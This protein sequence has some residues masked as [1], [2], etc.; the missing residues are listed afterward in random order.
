MNYYINEFKNGK[1]DNITEE[2]NDLGTEK[3][4]SIRKAIINNLNEWLNYLNI[5]QNDP[6]WKPRNNLFL[7]RINVSLDILTN[8]ND[9]EMGLQLMDL[10]KTI[11][12]YIDK[13]D[14]ENVK[15]IINKIKEL[16]N[17]NGI[18]KTKINYV[19]KENLDDSIKISKYEYELLKKYEE[20]SYKMQRTDFAL[21]INSGAV[22][23]A[24]HVN[25]NNDRVKLEIYDSNNHNIEINGEKY[26]IK[27]QALF[28]KI[29]SF[30]DNNL[31][32][33]I[34][35]SKKETNYFLDNNAYDGGK[36][37]NIKVKYGQLL[38]NV[39]GQVSGELGKNIED[40]INKIKELIISG[41]ISNDKDY[42]IY[43]LIENNQIEKNNSYSDNDET[44][45]LIVNEIEK[46]DDGAYFNFMELVNHFIELANVNSNSKVINLNKIYDAVLIKLE[47]S[48]INIKPVIT[49]ST[50]QSQE[51]L[52]IK[53]GK[54]EIPT[55]V[56]DLLKNF[57]SFDE[58]GYAFANQELPSELKTDYDTFIKN[59]YTN[60]N[61]K[62]V[63][64]I[65]NKIR[66]ISY[67][68]ETSIAELINY[69]P[70]EALV[71]PLT[72]GIIINAV[73]KMIII[74]N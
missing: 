8:I 63:N 59:Y 5:E 54:K 64:N 38:I 58:D 36:S 66:E 1:R 37:R 32:L 19:N 46:M 13:E 16:A 26:I 60:D 44:V 14:R 47:E 57:V 43:S 4:E 21:I 56:S 45:N 29:K 52:Y 31:D 18:N 41:S 28:N 51:K 69:K 10:A 25:Y 74:L 70:E 22:L 11:P 15:A 48:N 2:Q 12:N 34:D 55:E 39:N 20:D 23:P 17:G 67:N 65:V 68:T 49:N 9:N 35:W 72:Q 73:E 42:M 27:T 61:N 53:V 30:I 7:N 33:L 71:S 50:S 62:I 3:I 6:A 40:F 24:S